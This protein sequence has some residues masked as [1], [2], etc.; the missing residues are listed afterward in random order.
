M[1][2]RVLLLCLGKTST[3]T[4]IQADLRDSVLGLARRVS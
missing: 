4:H 2:P 1:G 3:D